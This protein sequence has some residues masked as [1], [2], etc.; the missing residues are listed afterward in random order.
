MMH[1]SKDDAV[2]PF[3]VK[4]AKSTLKAVAQEEK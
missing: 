2:T 1:V 4:W 3:C